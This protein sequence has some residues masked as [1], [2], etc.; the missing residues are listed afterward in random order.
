MVQWTDPAA[1]TA[2]KF[3]NSTNR[4]IFLTGRAGT[5]K[6]TFLHE[7]KERTHKD[8]I[9]AAPTAIAA[10]NAGGVTLHSLFQLPFG[11][12]LPSELGPEDAVPD[13]QFNTPLTLNRHLK[14]QAAK[15]N[16]L[17]KLELLIIDEVSMLRADLLDAVDS[18]LRRVRRRNQ[19]FGGV[20]ILFI[21]DLHQ[22]PPVVKSSEWQILNH[23]YTSQ[24]FFASQA[25]Q[26]QPPIP[27]ELSHIHRQTD[28][29]FISVLNNLRDHTLGRDDLALLNSRYRPGFRAGPQDGFIYLTT[30]NSKADRINRE[31]LAKL[32]GTT[33]EYNAEIQDAFEERLFP[34]DPVLALKTQAQVMFI[35]NDPSGE[36]RFFNGKI[37]RVESLK[38]DGIKVGFS[39]G[40]PSVWV[41]PYT[42]E[43]KRYTLNTET[44]EISEK[45]IGRFIHY[46]LKLAWAITV[47]KS[48]GLT[49][50]KAIVDVSQAFAAGQIYVA[51]SR[52]TSL[53]GLVLTAPLQERMIPQDPA[54]LSFTRE[55]QEQQHPEKHLPNAAFAY[56]SQVLEET[57][58]F[59]P[60]Q[61]ELQAHLLSYDKK[62]GQSKKQE[63]QDWARSLHTDFQEVKDVGN[64]FCKELKRI[65]PSAFDDTLVHLTDR[66]RA[67]KGYFEPLL[68]TFSKRVHEQ[69]TQV[70]Q[71]TRGVKQYLRELQDLEA[72]FYGRLQD[73]YKALDLISAYQKNEELTRST[74][75]RPQHAKAV[76]LAADA[77]P[78]K[79]P[80]AQDKPDTKRVSLE[81]FNQGK[82]IE[83][84][85]RERSLTVGTIQKHL[86]HWVEE[87]RLE[88][89]RLLSRGTLE[90][91]RAA[92]A[93]L[94]TTRLRPVYEHL[95]GKYDFAVLRFVTAAM[96]QLT[97][98]ESR[99]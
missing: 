62:A 16:L 10:I 58:D 61:S 37:G 88:V 35:K 7:I 32:P 98:R 17:K 28:Q 48:Q 33:F 42:W 3:I 39:D 74:L 19:A 85:A 72:L 91:I 26:E 86:T 20:Q 50:E 49:F 2:S 90:E 43:N 94:E 81:L 83:T 79:K 93:E 47:H 9:V 6:T 71:N 15:R 96:K 44:R 95:H 27:I 29:Q 45:V 14:M 76:S 53:D 89:D 18:V 78:V 56:L 40:S 82:S 41:E 70:Q 92:F 12:F 23:Y 54:L 52:L 60:I 8:A 1:L 57:F 34:V 22:L 65:L 97:A 59:S 36:Q 66:V 68:N 80:Q 24:F 84:I 30:H 5:G 63:H 51:L 87:G 11:A 69:A 38:A 64:R 99:E 67:A 73:I 25:L 55:Q 75:Q 13:F 77:K 4:H 46:P 31:E 21:G